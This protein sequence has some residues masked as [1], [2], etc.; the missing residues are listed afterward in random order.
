MYEDV[1]DDVYE[2]VYE[3]VY[4]E[5]DEKKT[6]PAGKRGVCRKVEF[7]TKVEPPVSHFLVSSQNGMIP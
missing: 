7:Q 1:Y 5:E 6:L 3:D 2:D 4:D